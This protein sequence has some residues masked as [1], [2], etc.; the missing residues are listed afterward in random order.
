VATKNVFESKR[1]SILSLIN[2]TLKNFSTED[3]NGFKLFHLTFAERGISPKRMFLI[4]R[5][6]FSNVLR[7]RVPREAYIL[8]S[9][10]L[11]TLFHPPMEFVPPTGIERIP[12][13][14]LPP[15][16]EMPL[17]EL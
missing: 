4:K 5:K 9:E 8:N 3:L 2:S 13:K 1:L 15:S 6:E 7:Y 11:A 17:P 14:E 16:P 10:E 12:I